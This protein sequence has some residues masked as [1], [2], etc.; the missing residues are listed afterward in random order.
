[1]DFLA[2]TGQPAPD[3]LALIPVSG[4]NGARL[5]S[6]PFVHTYASSGAGYPVGYMSSSGP[7]IAALPRG[8]LYILDAETGDVLNAPLTA[9]SRL[10][11]IEMLGTGEVRLLS[12]GKSFGLS[13]MGSMKTGRSFGRTA[14]F[15]KRIWGVIGGRA[16]SWRTTR[17]WGELIWP[18]GG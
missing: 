7:R 6:E 10:T 13:G 16:W 5:W 14:A 2:Q 15:M 17:L 12:G 11:P 1:M 3:R 8:L 18:R 4:S 9:V